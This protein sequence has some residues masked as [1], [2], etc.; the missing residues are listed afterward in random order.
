MNFPER[1]PKEEIDPAAA[2]EELR[3][4]RISPTEEELKRE[5]RKAIDAGENP[6]DAE[7]VY[8]LRLKKATNRLRQQPGRT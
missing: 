4:G 6:D 8:K 2:K 1:G 5:R 7:S 3:L